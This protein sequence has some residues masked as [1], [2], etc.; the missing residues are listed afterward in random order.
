[1]KGDQNQITFTL[2]SCDSTYLGGIDLRKYQRVV[3]LSQPLFIRVRRN[4]KLIRWIFWEEAMTGRLMETVP[5]RKKRK[6][7]SRLFIMKAFTCKFSV[8]VVYIFFPE[9]LL[10]FRCLSAVGLFGINWFDPK[11]DISSCCLHTNTHLHPCSVTVKLW[12]L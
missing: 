2:R 12:K 10:L 6:K 1:M 11:P 5:A 9:Y 4:M 7:K 3:G 8:C